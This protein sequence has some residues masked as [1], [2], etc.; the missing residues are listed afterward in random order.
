MAS[1]P[2]SNAMWCEPLPPSYSARSSLT[3]EEYSIE[4]EDHL[5]PTLDLRIQMNSHH[6]LPPSLP[7]TPLLPIHTKKSITQCREQHM[8]RLSLKKQGLRMFLLEALV[9]VETTYGRSSMEEEL[10]WIVS[11]RGILHHEDYCA[12]CRI[13]GLGDWEYCPLSRYYIRHPRHKCP[14]QQICTCG[15]DL[16][17]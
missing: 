2:A 12:D 9:K 13:G 6:P 17:D 8:C 5:P 15:Y 14:I 7:S 16:E 11:E 10:E 3:W 4:G 1:D